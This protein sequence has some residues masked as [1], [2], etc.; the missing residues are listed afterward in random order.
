MLVVAPFHPRRPAYAEDVIFIVPGS[1][2][3]SVKPSLDPTL[4]LIQKGQTVTFVNPDGLDHELVVKDSN[5]KQV[6]DT[7]VLN[8]NKFVS[9]TFAENGEYSIQDTTYAHIKGQIL[10]TDDVLTMTKA[11]EGQNID[12]QVTRTPAYPQI[13]Q[14]VYYK[15]TFIDKKTG[16]NHPHIDFTMTFNDSKGNYV[17]GVGGHSIDGQ[18][19]ARFKFDKQ[20]LLHPR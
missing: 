2:D 10:V 11:L 4:Q 7:G 6:F 1:S 3:P 8:Q 14:D 19:F 18:E 9:Y 15:V 13:N 20:I 5:G 12:V 17:N 16:R